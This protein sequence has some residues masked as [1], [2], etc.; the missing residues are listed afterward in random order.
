MKKK[1]YSSYTSSSAKTRYEDAE[2]ILKVVN[3]IEKL[4]YSDWNAVK[5]AADL[6]F[7]EKI[8][9]SKHEIKLT[10]VNEIKQFLWLC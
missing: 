4:R 6:A 3:G 1:T 2:Q 9:K 10:N 7:E 5:A 8:N